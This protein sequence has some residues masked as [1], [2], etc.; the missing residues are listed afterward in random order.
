MFLLIKQERQMAEGHIFVLTAPASRKDCCIIERVPFVATP[1]IVSICLPSRFFKSVIQLLLSSPSIITLQAPQCPVP[2]ASFVPLR[3]FMLRRYFNR[4]VL[5]SYS[6]LISC[7]LR[8]N[9]TM[10]I[11]IRPFLFKLFLCYH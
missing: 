7:P 5:L 9:E 8:T 3:H 2:Q 1:S 10:D 11:Y 6:V 4:V